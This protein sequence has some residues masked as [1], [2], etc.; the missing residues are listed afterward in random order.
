MVVANNGQHEP[1]RLQRPAD[2]LSRDRMLLHHRPFF[3]S[4]V[5]IFLLQKNL[6]RHGNFAEIVQI[7]APAQR[8]DRFFVQPKISAESA[9]VLR[10]SL[11]MPLSIRI[12]ALYG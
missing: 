4:K 6:I 1:Q 12:T 8:H 3:G 9:R 5:R 7:A 2:I 10:Q 11:A